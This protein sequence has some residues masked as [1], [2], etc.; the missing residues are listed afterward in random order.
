MKIA[1]VLVTF[2]R[3]ADL[4]KAIHCYEDQTNLMDYLIIVNNAST[5]GTKEYLE[6]WSENDSKYEKIVVHSSSNTGGSGGFYTGLKE[7]L[8]YDYDYVFLADDDAF[9]DPLMIEK[10]KS[11]YDMHKDKQN[12]VGMCTSVINHGKIDCMHRRRVIT[13]F[14]SIKNVWIPKEEYEKPYFAVDEFSFV[15]AFIRKD[16]IEKIGLPCKEYFIY[17]DDTEYSTR[18][19]KCG[20]IFCIPDS[21]MNHNSVIDNKTSWKDY[22]VLRNSADYLKK[23]YS[24]RHYYW[25]LL[26]QYVK[27]CTFLANIYKQRTPAQKRMFKIAIKDSRNNKLGIHPIYKPGVDIE[28]V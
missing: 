14:L 17:Y 23:H 12:I 3:L 9:A 18:I 19:R 16:I 26:V 7:S 4:K 20:N 10:I 1:V 6:S 5:D 22:Y 8:K 27:K 24:K 15:G 2:N 21:K 11:F 28:Q 13:K 25:Y